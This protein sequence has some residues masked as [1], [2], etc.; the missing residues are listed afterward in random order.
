MR[1]FESPYIADWFAVS[2]RWIVLVGIIIFLAL[3]Q[4][5]TSTPFGPLLIMLAWN[6]L[7]SIL[8]GMSIRLRNYHRQV[9]LAVD[10]VLAA[11]F[12]WVQG[13]LAGPA[14]WIGL[15]PILTGAVYFEMWGAFAAGIAF[16][17]F[18]Y[19][20]ASN[21]F[22]RLLETP[23]LSSILLTVLMGLASG[24][25]GHY[26]M[27][28]L[29]YER[30]TRVDADERRRRMESE[31]LRAI[32]E[33]TS[34]LTATLSY[35]RVLDSALDLGYTA[36]NPTPDPEEATVDEKLVSAV[37]LFQGD[38]LQVGSARRFSLVRRQ[39]RWP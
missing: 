13:G 35:K 31:R 20:A 14:A 6:T 5:L 8:A 4:Q 3:N 24:L 32:Y 34:T 33:L 37:L 16:A 9:V 12:F 18:Q 25:I 28:R 19:V 39:R 7:L 23:A 22:R 10:F 26:L 15:M 38:E 36:L 1:R 17:A 30:Q 29:R 2:L 27:R 21:L 11:I